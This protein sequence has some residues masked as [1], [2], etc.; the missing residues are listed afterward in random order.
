MPPPKSEQLQVL[1]EVWG[2][3]AKIEAPRQYIAVASTYLRLLVKEFGAAEVQK[4]LRD[5]VKRV[6]PDK[7]RVGL[8]FCL[9]SSE[10]AAARED[11]A[12]S[13]VSCG[14]ERCTAPATGWGGGAG[15]VVMIIAVQGG[16]IFAWEWACVWPIAVVE[17]Q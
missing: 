13:L 11:R 7:A 2:E 12:R 15:G 10:P 4:L 14:G 9:Y 17:G 8:R 6:T 16:A 3:I 1:N 5:I